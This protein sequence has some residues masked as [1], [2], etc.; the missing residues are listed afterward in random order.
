MLEKKDREF[1]K[2][3]L[4]KRLGLYSINDAKNKEFKIPKQK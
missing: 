3:Y 4:F 1:I 2:S